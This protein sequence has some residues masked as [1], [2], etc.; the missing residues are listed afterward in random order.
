MFLLAFRIDV[1][2]TLQKSSLSLPPPAQHDRP[3]LQ[4]TANENYLP[5]SRR[6]V[7]SV[8]SSTSAQ[9]DK[10]DHW[11]AQIAKGCCQNP[12]CI[13]YTRISC[14]KCGLCLCLNNKNSCFKDYH[15]K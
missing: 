13:E 2:K 12:N 10:Y 15:H 6:K 3:S 5:N 1:A 4:S 14:S 9:L 11:P 8:A 7:L